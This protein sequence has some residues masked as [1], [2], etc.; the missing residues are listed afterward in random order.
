MTGKIIKI[1]FFSTFIVLTNCSPT[2]PQ[3]YWPYSKVPPQKLKILNPIEYEDCM[4]MLDSILSDEVKD[5]FKNSDSTIATIEICEGIGGFFITNWEL[6][7]YG[8]TKGTTNNG[9]RQRLPDRPI[10]LPSQFIHDGIEHPHSMI[11]VMFNCYYK[12]QNDKKY[13]WEDE[14]NKMKSY[15]INPEII[16]YYTRVPDTIA[17]IENKILVDYYFEILNKNDTVNIFYNRAPRWTK[18]SPDWYYL[19]GIIQNKK[20]QTKQINVKLIDIKSEFGDNFILTENNTIII[21]DT[22]TDHSKGWLKKGRHYFNYNK[23]TEYRTGI[24]KILPPTTN[25]PAIDKNKY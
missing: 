2:N 8:K 24:E 11:R 23:N 25:N 17:K 9:A 19:T 4:Y 12:Y 10:N 21:G 3:F 18:K 14:I 5:N 1:I 22:L 6:N 15:W 7:R 16:Y 13:S 20:Q